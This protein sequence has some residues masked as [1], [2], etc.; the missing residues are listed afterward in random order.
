MKTQIRIILASLF[1]ILPSL[2]YAYS[3]SA[4]QFISALADLL[5]RKVIGDEELVVLIDAAGEGYIPNPISEEKAELSVEHF[6][7]RQMLQDY[8]DAE[9]LDVTTVSAWAK[10]NLIEQKQQRKNREEAREETALP[11]RNSAQDMLSAGQYTTYALNADGILVCWG[12]YNST[13]DLGVVQSISSRN[14]A[15]CV[16]KADGT[17]ACWGRIYY[18]DI[19]PPED[20]GVVR[21]V[22]VGEHLICSVKGNGTVRCWG[23]PEDPNL[24]ANLGIVQSVSTG[25]FHACAV[26]AD[27]TVACWGH[28]GHKQSSPP[29]ELGVVQSVSGGGIHTCAVK[30]DG[31]VVCWGFKDARIAVP[32][33]LGV[34]QFV[35]AGT[36]HNCAIKADGMVTCWG[37]NYFGEVNPP[38]DLGIVK[39]VS[40]GALYSCAVNA[41][42]VVVCWGAT[43]IHGQGI[44]P[45]GLRVMEVRK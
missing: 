7:S 35:S 36:S 34:V 45:A 16:V 1:Y 6:V 4:N 20:L 28:D 41:D 21:S 2:S 11:W 15:N 30:I 37:L 9:N 43:T 12:Q 40:A 23:G 31:K 39:S 44:P 32:P 8:V 25:S 24:P 42:S 5:E 13:P 10:E 26:K 29:A 19:N 14:Q 3:N 33:E 18:G 17:A 38:S 22:S 27:G